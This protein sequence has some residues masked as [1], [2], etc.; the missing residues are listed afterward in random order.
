MAIRI[1]IA[2]DHELVRQAL[3]SLIESHQGWEVCGDADDGDEAVT[4]AAE[5]C[6][7]VI[8]LDLAMPR[9]DGLEAARHIHKAAP[10]IPIILHTM[11]SSP[12]VERAAQVMGIYKVTSKSNSMGLCAELESLFPVSAS[13]LTESLGTPRVSQPDEPK[14]A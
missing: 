3:R 10:H 2:D 6:P 14:S 13:K 1:L 8:I 5:L 7:D 12:A 9:M 4:K 11:H